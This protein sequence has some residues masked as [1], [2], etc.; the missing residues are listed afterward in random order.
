MAKTKDKAVERYALNSDDRKKDEFD[1]IREY[2]FTGGKKKL[3]AR[4]EELLKKLDAINQLL[5]NGY[6]VNNC[7]KKI[8]MDFGISH[9]HAYRLIQKTQTLYG[10]AE[11]SSKEGKRYVLY[12]M[13]MRAA[14]KAYEIGDMQSYN[15]ACDSIAKLYGLFDNA[16]VNIDISQIIMPKTIVLNSDL[17]TLKNEMEQNAKTIELLDE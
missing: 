10:N 5:V 9:V 12:E 14:K 3:S 6:S 13:Y 7:S 16:A 1:R 2:M 4:D 17:E 15:H 11:Q 8:Q